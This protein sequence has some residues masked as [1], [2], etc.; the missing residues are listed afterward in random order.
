MLSKKKKNVCMIL[1]PLHS[2]LE[3]DLGPQ[4]GK[5][6]K[7]PKANINTHIYSLN[8]LSVDLRHSWKNSRLELSHKPRVVESC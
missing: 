3:L 6:H 2:S 1:V 7:V 5:F 4:G 8:L